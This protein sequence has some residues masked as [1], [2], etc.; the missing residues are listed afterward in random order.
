MVKSKIL[1]KLFGIVLAL[2]GAIILIEIIPVL[3]WYC[4]LGSLCI[5]ILLVLFKKI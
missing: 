1:R 2:G 3:I 5:F 4:I